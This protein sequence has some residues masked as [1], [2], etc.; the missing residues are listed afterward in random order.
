MKKLLEDKKIILL[1]TVL[2]LLIIF[3]AYIKTSEVKLSEIYQK[4]EQTEEELLFKDEERAE[5]NEKI[6][7]NKTKISAENNKDSK[8][9]AAV[10]KIA[11]ISEIKDPFKAGSDSSSDKRE[12]A[13]EAQGEIKI[14]S[15]TNYPGELIDLEKNILAQNL[16]ES[17]AG[18]KKIQQQRGLNESELNS[19]VSREAQSAAVEEKLN[20][21][22]L[23]LPFKL[24]GII[25]NDNNSSVLLQY[26]G[27]TV[28]KNAKDKIGRFTIKEIKNQEIV[29]SYQ[30]AERIIKLWEDGK[31]EN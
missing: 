19:K 29:I 6:T 18:D 21:D 15:K 2:L 3:S 7:E 13:A 16:I 4:P 26:Q 1:L 24:L 11:L 27:Q 20:L 25:K 31:N 28:V 9:K 5:N 12:T 14:N 23:K 8:D 17:A 30:K 22:K 10:S